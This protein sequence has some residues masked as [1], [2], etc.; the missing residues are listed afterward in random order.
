MKF[1]HLIRE[2]EGLPSFIADLLESD[3]AKNLPRCGYKE[4]S[5]LAK[6]I[7]GQRVEQKKGYSYILQIPGT[8]HHG[9]W[10]SKSIYIMKMSLLGLLHQLDLHWQ[11]KKKVQ[12]K[13]L[14]VVFAFVPAWFSAKIG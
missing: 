7:L 10:M 5:E 11:T 13:A 4:F 2:K 6:I 9:C 3:S 1:L 8:D 12:K 14:L